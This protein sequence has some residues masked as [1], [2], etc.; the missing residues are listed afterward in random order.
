MFNFTEDYKN[1]VPIEHRQKFGQFFTPDAIAKLMC[2]WVLASGCDSIFDPAFG[3]GAFYNALRSFSPTIKY[4]AVE[5][6]EKIIS[7]FKSKI[8]KDDSFFQLVKGN[9]LTCKNINADAIICNPPY[10]R[11]QNF[12][13]RHSILKQLHEQFG[14]KINGYTNIASVFLLKSISELRPMGRLAYIMPSEFLNTGYGEVVKEQLLK[15][16]L[17]KYLIKI[18]AEKEVF[19]DV[20]TTISILLLSKDNVPSSVKFLSVNSISDLTMENVADTSSG[21]YMDLNKIDPCSKW[22]CHFD[23]N[24]I[25]V[26]E[27]FMVPLSYY[28]LFSRGIATGAN[29]FFALSNSDIQK[30][31][32][33]D[34]HV[35]MCITKSAQIKRPVFDE[36]QLTLLVKADA[37]VYLLNAY[38]DLP[39]GVQA[40]IEYGQEMGFNR[41]Y[42]TKCRN[43][44]YRIETRKP[45]PILLGV[46]SRNGYKVVRNLTSAVSLTCFHGFCPNIFGI[47][48]VD[49]LFVYLNSQTGRMI[50]RKDQR[51]YGDA[52]DKFEP[53]DL[54]RA[55]VPSMEVFDS[56]D[57]YLLKSLIND[58]TNK[59]LLYKIDDLFQR[60]LLNGPLEISEKR[61]VS[62]L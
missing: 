4:N 23:E 2:E 15:D 43:P 6:D 44:W 27:K 26:K 14:F 41:R 9:Y 40:Y 38:G 51:H 50:L 16:G 55:L 10:Q 39:H 8:T 58:I 32:L 47:K 35:K 49:H 53:N 11:F 13:N 42:L 25:P 30:L 17:L 54:N 24:H 21:K 12:K 61:V 37:P 28:G 19:P 3:L 31:N 60:A 56:I 48:Y 57:S 18:D 34:K 7:F 45:A 36:E 20:T 1:N 59:D 62:V 22:M 5:I 29:D 52:L 33:P 46:F